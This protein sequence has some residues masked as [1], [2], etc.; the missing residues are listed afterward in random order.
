MIVKDESA[1]IAR[2]LESVKPLIDSWAI[3]DTG[4]T[5]DTKRIIGEVMGD[6]PGELQTVIPDERA[7]WWQRKRPFHFAK[8]RN[9]ALE[10]AR[11]LGTDYIL[12][13]DADEQVILDPGADGSFPELDASRYVAKFRLMPTRRMWHRSFLIRSSDPWEYR[14][15]VHEALY[16]EGPENKN[17]KELSGLEVYSF[18]DGARN[19]DARTKFLRDAWACKL[20]I[21]EEP[22]EPRHWFYLGQSLGSA[23]EFLKAYQAYE[24][25]ASMPGGW[26]EERWYAL[27]QLAPLRELLGCHWRDVLQAYLTAY[28]ARPW[29]AEPL[30]AA[31]L[32]CTDHGEPALGELYLR[33][34]ASMPQPP[35][36]FLVDEDIYRWRALD[37]LAGCYANKLGQKD[38][39]V[40]ALKRLLDSGRLP[41]EHVERVKGNLEL[42]MA[43]P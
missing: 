42:A 3:T 40:G 37:D 25:R 39:C 13:I 18:S 19:A 14:H 30:W 29:R 26:D 31:G 33:Q 8:Y 17:A 16:C 41:E 34:A 32:L 15:R 21:K 11:K 10:Q 20:A 27:Y 6:K 1:V 7:R 38:A 36:S 5:D 12:L 23:G 28:V 2:C 24:K 43:Q 9:I 35:D 22:N 4:S